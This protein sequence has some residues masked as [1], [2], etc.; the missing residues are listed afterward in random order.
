MD[1]RKRLERERLEVYFAHILMAYR[2]IIIFF[3]G[4]LLIC[5]AAFL[6]NAA[7]FGAIIGVAAALTLLLGFSYQAIVLCARA[8]AWIATVGRN[9]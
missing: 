4:F 7:S 8:G 1:K 6:I 2:P 5:A 9:V 3:G